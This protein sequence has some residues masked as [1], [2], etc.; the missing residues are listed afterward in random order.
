MNFLAAL[1]WKLSKKYY[2]YLHVLYNILDYMYLYIYRYLLPIYNNDS[3]TSVLSSRKHVN[4]YLSV[5]AL[6][7]GGENWE[8]KR[9]ECILYAW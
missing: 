9:V 5:D 8:V 6:Y 7:R 3:G 2:I 4:G 1:Y